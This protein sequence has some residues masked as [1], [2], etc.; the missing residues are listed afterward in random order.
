MPPFCYSG[1]GTGD[2]F[3]C[4]NFIGELKREMERSIVGFSL[5]NIKVVMCLWQFDVP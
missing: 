2:T 1:H 3:Y 4:K 5:V